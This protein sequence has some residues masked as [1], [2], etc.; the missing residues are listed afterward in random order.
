MGGRGS[1]IHA[2]THQAIGGVLDVETRPVR[3]PVPEP[4][5]VL[6]QLLAELGLAPMEP[7]A[8]EDPTHGDGI[9]ICAAN[10]TRDSL[11]EYTAPPSGRQ[12]V[13]KETT[14]Q[15]FSLKRRKSE[16]EDR[17]LLGSWAFYVCVCLCR[18]FGRRVRLTPS[19]DKLVFSIFQ[20]DFN[21]RTGSYYGQ[22]LL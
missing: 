12:R 17:I 2:H 18:N 10:H 9:T 22:L 7:E 5:R 15:A 11:S 8:R 14:K 1:P 20:T 13:C 3:A 16:N 19:R 6:D 21:P 4:A